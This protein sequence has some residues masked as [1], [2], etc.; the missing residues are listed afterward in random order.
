[1]PT[2]TKTTTYATQSFEVTEHSY[3]RDNGV[4]FDTYGGD[5]EYACMPYYDIH[6]DA[7]IYGIDVAIMEGGEPGS[8][9][10]TF[11]STSMTL[12]TGDG[13]LAPLT[14]CFLWLNQGPTSMQM[15]QTAALA[16]LSGTLSN[17]K[18]PAGHS[19]S[20]LGASFE[21][22]GGA[23]LTIAESST[24]FDGTAAI[25]GPA[26]SDG[27]YAWRGTDE[28]PMVRLNFDP[29]IEPTVSGG[30]AGCT[31][32]QA[33]NF[34]PALGATLDDLSC[35]YFDALGVCG[36]DCSLDSNGDGVCDLLGC[37]ALF[38]SEYVE[39]FG[40]NKA[41]EIYNPTPVCGLERLPN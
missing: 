8:P 11:A 41:L 17:S 13:F 15:C 30:I 1:M 20:T 10:R 28:M 21:Y 33:C 9:I 6:N 29:N 12:R 38:F 31:D 18:S 34:D 40:N 7:T 35:L 32:P 22:F 3:G 19:R 36:G 23:A 24:N 5:F 37:D 25:Y 27:S 39:G 4:I 14:T 2:T 16:K 26:A